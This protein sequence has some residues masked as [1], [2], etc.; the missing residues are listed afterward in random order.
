MTKTEQKQFEELETLVSQLEKQLD[1]TSD[2][3][4]KLFAELKKEKEVNEDLQAIVLNAYYQAEEL[5]HNL[6]TLLRK[7]NGKT[8]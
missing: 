6:M 2:R 8:N 1:R 4:A 7:V 5:Q 3:E